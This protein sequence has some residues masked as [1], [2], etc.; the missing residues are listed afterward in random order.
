M[1][2]NKNKVV[3]YGGNGLKFNEDGDSRPRIQ[4]ID[5]DL[6]SLYHKRGSAFIHKDDIDDLIIL[7]QEVKAH[8]YKIDY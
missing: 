4:D 5:D 6:F 3:E 7:L 2:K 1:L 8:N